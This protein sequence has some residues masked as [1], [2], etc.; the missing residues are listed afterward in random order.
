MD[1]FSQHPDR[2]RDNPGDKS[3]RWIPRNITTIE[4]WMSG[5]PW[6]FNPNPGGLTGSS[7]RFIT[8][9]NGGKSTAT[10][11]ISVDY[12]RDNILGE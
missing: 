5:L 11:K 12:R 8:D 4:M 6:T 10:S 2:V 9:C 7:Q 3:A 1:S